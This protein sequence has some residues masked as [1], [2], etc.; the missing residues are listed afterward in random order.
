MK[1]TKNS[2]D[3]MKNDA[4][5][6][7]KYYGPWLM[8]LSLTAAILARAAS[9]TILWDDKM[10]VI[11]YPMEALLY[12]ATAFAFY[13]LTLRLR[14]SCGL[15]L[16]L[17][18]LFPAANDYVFQFR[19]DPIKPGDLLSLG[20]AKNVAAG[21]SLWPIPENLKLVMALSVGT[22]LLLFTVQPL[23]I[24]T[25]GGSES[26]AAQSPELRLR[27]MRR[28]IRLGAAALA[29]ALG[30]ATFCGAAGL[31][32]HWKNSGSLRNGFY[33]NFFAQVHQ[34][35]IK[36]P[37]G[38]SPEAVEAMASIYDTGTGEVA[39]SDGAVGFDGQKPTI[40]VIMDESFA[41]FSELG[42]PLR[43]D[44]PVTPFIDS[45]KENTVR[46]Y[47]LTSVFGG[48][49]A[50][51]EWE[52]LTGHSMA[53]M[54]A[55]SVP[56]QQYVRD[57]AYSLVTDLKALGYRCL[58]MH[59]F[60]P[61]GWNR[62]AVYETFGFDYSYFLNDFPH[63]DVVRSFI[64]DK[65]MV[66]KIISIYNDLRD[67]DVF[68]FGITMQNHGGYD[69]EGRNY[70][71][72]TVHLEGYEGEYP[73]AEQYLTLLHETDEAVRFLI[74]YFQRESRPVII[75]FFGDHFPQ[76][77]EELFEEI[78]GGSF[79]TLEEQMQLYSVPYFIWAN[80]DIE[81]E[82]NALTSL[83]FLAGDVLKMAGL[84][85]SP[86]RSYLSDLEEIVPAMNVSGYYSRAEQQFL[87]LDR[88]T[89][90]EAA[91]LNDDHLLQYNA[92]FDEEERNGTM[93]PV[94]NGAVLW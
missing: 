62:P 44:Q 73:L 64:S 23:G 52:F 68:L 7:L 53:W 76:V 21:Y 19:G 35:W 94:S 30:G 42:S 77:E 86:Y 16:A 38:Y 59:P 88:A 89:G 25:V 49:T 54:P 26:C 34:L 83:N 2:K 15:A 13:A 70:D 24:P 90:E 81:E 71:G 32:Q 22:V 33:M 80:Y 61:D 92:L 58:S 85:L 31:P 1:N 18:L 75:A 45:L 74:E 8:L 29:I 51:A 55:G 4:R 10:N 91:A 82:E 37:D 11:T 3:T 39:G 79:D 93:F 87:P 28:R 43:T 41:D 84:S 65:E 66:W 27:Q 60:R 50:N 40:I 5:N 63:E 69:Y 14:L 78:H 57:E 67:Q 72:P 12:L 48:T 6:A 17:F 36:S 9:G 47:A 56:Y 46:G 20:T